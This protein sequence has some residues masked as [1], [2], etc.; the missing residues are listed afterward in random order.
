MK[1]RARGVD[2]LGLLIFQNGAH[3]SRVIPVFSLIDSLL[4]SRVIAV[5]ALL[6]FKQ[7][8]YLLA[9]MHT[10]LLIDVAHVGLHRIF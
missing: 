3:L 9:R 8:A 7:P 6:R 10:D 4:G 5:L 1:R 2:R